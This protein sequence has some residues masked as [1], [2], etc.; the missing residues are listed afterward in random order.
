MRVLHIG[1][2]PPPYGGVAV[3]MDT[4][5]I[6]ERNLGTSCEVL[7][8]SAHGSREVIGRASLKDILRAAFVMMVLV[9]K[10]IKGKFDLVHIHS[11]DDVGFVRD[12]GLVE[13]CALFRKPVVLHIHG[14]LHTRVFPGNNAIFRSLFE[15][16][17]KRINGAVVLGHDIQRRLGETK[18]IVVPNPHTFS[19]KE[20]QYLHNRKVPCDDG[21]PA[22]LLFIGRLSNEK[23]VFDFIRLVEALNMNGYMVE[24]IFAGTAPDA[25]D[26]RAFDSAIKNKPFLK[27]LGQVAGNSKV[28]VFHQTDLLVFPSYKEILPVSVIEALAAGVPA[29]VYDVGVVDS[30]VTHGVNGL[31][32]TRGDEQALYDN[33]QALFEDRAHWARLSANAKAASTA[34]SSEEIVRQM[35]AFYGSILADIKTG[36]LVEGR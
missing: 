7:D 35:M 2:V 4:V 16:T 3:T 12:A 8:T 14:D 28:E 29:V 17:R 21:R 32:V 27:A 10:L 19:E 24:G 13:I 36:R 20:I 18:S 30:I 6:A 9:G 11:T 26:Q 5:I 23:G 22:K 1:P 25:K 15:R 34:L 33:V 31:V